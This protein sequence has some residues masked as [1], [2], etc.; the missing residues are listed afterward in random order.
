MRF[1]IS[2]DTDI[3]SA[4]FADLRSHPPNVSHLRSHTPEVP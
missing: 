3:L 2:I 4:G 1:N